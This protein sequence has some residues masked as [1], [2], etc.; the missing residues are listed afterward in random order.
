[1]AFDKEK[2]KELI[3]IIDKLFDVI[4]VENKTLKDSIKK[5]VLG[6]AIEEIRKMVEDSRPPVL[7]LMGRSGH[8]KS[9]LINALAG[10]E[11][12]I[13][14]DFQPQEPQSEPYLITFL[15]ENSVWKVIDTRGIF[16]STKPDG[17][18]EDNAMKVLKDNILHHKPDILMHVISTPEVRSMQM[19]LEFRKELKTFIQKELK[20]DIPLLM[21]LNKADTFKNPREWPPEK[22]PTKAAQLDE[23]MNY[24]INDIL[25]A[26]KK[27]I[28]LTIPYYGYT[29]EK[30]DYLAI[31]PVCTLED[32]LWN[33]DNLSDLI[34]TNLN[35]SAQLDFYQAQKRKKPLK[36][37][38]SSIIKRFSTIAGGVG[39][40]PIPVSDIALL[41]PLQ[42]LMIT[43]IGALAG[44]ELTKET[45][46][47]YL[48]TAGINIGAGVG[49]REIARQGAKL[50]PFGSVVIS[51]PLAASSTWAIG[52][53]AELYFFNEKIVKPKDIDQEM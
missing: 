41:V 28:N 2:M 47:E 40:T 24:V 6:P 29:L 1:M 32:D 43:V 13:V 15:E 39:A 49:L 25:K 53:S 16:E 45:A 31:V 17:S 8:G 33:I 38:S 11:V 4:P 34:G 50:V 14:N 20:F 51:G 23:Q 19:D 18:I 9:S 22:Y 10:K 52:K 26:Q 12:A 5:I 36:A 3:T 21:I 37:F 7:M 42:L 46:L 48:A 30:S 27:Q 35:Q 44:R